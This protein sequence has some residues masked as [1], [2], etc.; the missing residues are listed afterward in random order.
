LTQEDSSLIGF[1][2]TC[3]FCD[4]I[5]IKELRVWAEHMVR[6]YEVGDL[7]D[8][9]FDLCDFNGELKD[10]SKTIGFVSDWECP[11]KDRHALLGI[12]ERRGVEPFDWPISAVTARNALNLNPKLLHRFQ[13]VFPFI[14]F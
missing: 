2:V 6:Q 11:K 14:Q 12:A 5:D 9:I 10:L 1:V 3:V 8:Y 13:Q 7:P 4:A